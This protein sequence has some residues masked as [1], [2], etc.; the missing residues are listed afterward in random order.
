MNIK[1][2]ILFCIFAHFAIAGG[3]NTNTNQSIA[4]QR[5]VARYATTEADAPIYNPAGTAFMNDGWHISLNSQA[6]W[7]SRTIDT[8][9]PLFGGEKEFKGLAQI[10]VMPSLL[11]SW[12]RGN[13]AISGYFGITG[14]GGKLD[15]KKGIPSFEAAI[16]QIPGALTLN[17]LEATAYDVDFS[18]KGTSYIFGFGLGAAYKIHDMFA[19]YLGARFSYAYNHYEASLTNIQVNPKNKQ[20]GLDGSM[21]EAAATFNELSET[22]A[23][24][25][26]QAAGAAKLY[27]SKGDKASAAEY[28]AK[29]TEYATKSQTFAGIAQSVGDK[30]LDVTQTGWGIT[31]VAGLA[32]NYK[33]LSIGV[34][35]EYNTAIEMEN[36]TKK[37]DVNIESFEDGVKGDNDIPASIYA[38]IA[39][40][41]LDNARICLGYGHWFDS[42]ADLPGDQ[43][44]YADGTDEFLYGVEIDFLT[45]W[46]ISGGVQVTR[47]H[48]SDEYLSDMSIILDNTTFGFG[49]AFRATDWLKFNVGYFHSLYNN[50]E[51]TETYG[52]NTYKRSSRG[53]GIG[54]DFDF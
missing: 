24:Y 39:Y 42:S 32:F 13:L 19:A 46:T 41:I 43:E 37:N 20:L 9:S 54:A 47:Y 49:F 31:P 52:I 33:R 48:L 12:H 26:D 6:F 44:K 11:A 22:F 27:A 50:S 5:N 15:Y 7:Q 34:K 3:L 30:E 18:L 40:S 51:E 29:A 35:F 4:Y 10:P 17:G 8:E 1:I 45:R 25:A 38:G 2:P 14:G 53:V 16:A 36:D 23:E 21:V 28:E